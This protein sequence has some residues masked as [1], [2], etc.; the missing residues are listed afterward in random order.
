MLSVI[1]LYSRR[2]VGWSI[3]KRMTK[4]LVMDAILMAIRRHKPA[5]GLIFHSDIGSQYC[6]HAFQKLLHTHAIRSSI[7]RKG[8][9]W[10]NAVAEKVSLE[11][12]IQ[13]LYL[14]RDLKH[15]YR[16]K[17]ILLITSNV[18]Q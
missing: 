9:C 16:Q 17:G 12:S 3:D 6:S 13:R 1:D 10:D 15:A 11:R 5:P 7:S 2:V 18:L 14:E 8:D 4:Q